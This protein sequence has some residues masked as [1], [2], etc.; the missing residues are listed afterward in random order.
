MVENVLGWEPGSA[1]RTLEGGTPA[2]KDS[3]VLQEVVRLAL[4]DS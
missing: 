4:Q 3:R 2:V 1:Q